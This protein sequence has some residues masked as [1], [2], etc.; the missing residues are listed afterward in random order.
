MWKK[1]RNA[2]QESLIIII[3]GLCCQASLILYYNSNIK[4]RSES[5]DRIGTIQYY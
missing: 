1:T 5:S 4:I 2:N 3:N